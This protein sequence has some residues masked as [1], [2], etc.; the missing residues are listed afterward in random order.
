MSRCLLVNRFK[1]IWY[2]IIVFLS[3]C[4]IYLKCYSYAILRVNVV[5]KTKVDLN[6]Y[7]I[8]KYS[9]VRAGNYLVNISRLQY[10]INGRKLESI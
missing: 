3:D 1:L 8:M 7:C 2:G 4:P 5:T 6:N 10:L 9:A